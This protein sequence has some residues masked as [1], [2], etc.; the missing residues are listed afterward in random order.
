MT[1]RRGDRTSLALHVHT[2]LS[3]L[4]QGNQDHALHHRWRDVL[5]ADDDEKLFDGLK[6][7]S[8]ALAELRRQVEACPWIEASK[9][10]HLANIKGWGILLSAKSLHTPAKSHMGLLQS[11]QLNHLLSLN[12]TL[13]QWYPRARLR[14][15]TIATLKGRIDAL[16][17]EVRTSDLE[18]ELK[19]YIVA[20]LSALAWALANLDYFGTDGVYEIVTAVM[21]RHR[22]RSVPPTDD[23]QAA[24][25]FQKF[26][27]LNVRFWR[28]LDYV[29]QLEHGRAA[30]EALWKS[31][32]SD[33]GPPALPPPG[34]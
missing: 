34:I 6:L 14:T 13:V 2:A 9:P 8:R 31:F 15:S 12:D 3:A 24:K 19:G 4:S 21:A 29:V 33:G 22:A 17:E 7:L 1:P 28:M 23:P 26:G 5:A 27:V 32:F 25:M 18:Q 10:M 30:V 16:L 11:Q 20:Q